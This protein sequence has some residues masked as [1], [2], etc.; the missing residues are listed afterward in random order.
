MNKFCAMTAAL[1][2]GLF[3]IIALYWMSSSILVAAQKQ[4]SLVI[5]FDVTSS[6][7]DDMEDMKAGA[8]MLAEKIANAKNKPVENFI[9]VP[10][11]DPRK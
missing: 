8:H 5:I 7:E 10:F 2:K 9:L 3:S 6:M 4:R 11:T 1:I